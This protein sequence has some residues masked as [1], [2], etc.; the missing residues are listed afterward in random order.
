MSLKTWSFFF[1]FLL[2][3]C[4]PIYLLLTSKESLAWQRRLSPSYPNGSRIGLNSPFSCFDVLEYSWDFS[5]WSMKMEKEKK[6]PRGLKGYIRC[7]YL[8]PKK[9]VYWG[10]G[11]P[12]KIIVRTG[13][14]ASAFLAAS[15]PKKGFFTLSSSPNLPILF[16]CCFESF[17]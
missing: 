8:P 7:Y 11:D 1:F 15:A 6:S 4:R 13:T 5:I 14:A 10:S 16:P 3:K 9:Y 12:P 17:Y 2:I